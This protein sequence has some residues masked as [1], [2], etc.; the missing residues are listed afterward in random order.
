MDHTDA[1]S[2]VPAAWHERLRGYRWTEA[3][4]GCSEAAVFRLDAPGE[5]ALYL[6]TEPA[7]P[8]AELP[9]EAERLRWLDAAGIPCAPVRGFMEEAGHDWMLLGAVQ[10]RNLE[11]A[12][13]DPAIAVRLLATR[14]VGEVLGPEW[15]A[16]F[17]SEYGAAPDPE[18]AAFYRLLDEFF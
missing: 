11:E 4:Q 9:G 17:L 2:R 10:G 8:L 14:D 16:P 15:V 13:L 7:G 1:A 6:K 3:T 12:G 18:R 5:P